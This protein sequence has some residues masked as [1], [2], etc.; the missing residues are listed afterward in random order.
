MTESRGDLLLVKLLADDLSA[1]VDAPSLSHRAQLWCG[2]LYRDGRRELWEI[3]GVKG[4]TTVVG[5]LREPG[6]PWERQQCSA[7]GMAFV[8]AV[9]QLTDLFE[10]S[11]DVITRFVVGPDGPSPEVLIEAISVV[12]GVAS[13]TDW[14][15]WIDVPWDEDLDID[16]FCPSIDWFHVWVMIDDLRITALRATVDG[17]AVVVP[18]LM[19]LDPGDVPEWHAIEV[20]SESSWHNEGGG[21]PVSWTGWNS[22]KRLNERVAVGSQ[23]GDDSRED[24]LLVLPT[25]DSRAG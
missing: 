3:S 5:Y 21:A 23:R 16:A 20:I 13:T 17:E 9:R 12:D 24:S 11:P 7:V 1:L 19:D 15:D 14:P 10:L 22:V 6:S 4:V 18:V 2:R 25:N 8:D